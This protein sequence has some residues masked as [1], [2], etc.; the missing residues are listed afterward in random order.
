MTIPADTFIITEPRVIEIEL[1]IEKGKT[2]GYKVVIDNKVLIE[3]IVEYP[4]NG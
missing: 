3:E 1:T 4:E 2:A